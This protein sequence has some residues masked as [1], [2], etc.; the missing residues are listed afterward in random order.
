MPTT[1][2][3]HARSERTRNAVAEAMLDCFEDGLLR[4]GAHEVAER[5][6]VSTRA[7]FRH[8]DSMETLIEQVSEFQIERVM[9]QLPPVAFEGTREERVAALVARTSRAFELVAPVRRAA[10]LLEPFSRTIRE[11]HAWLRTEIRRSVRRAF[12]E[13]LD[14]LT[15]SRQRDRIAGLRALLSY[16]YWDELRRHE[17]LAVAAATRTLSA[18]IHALLRS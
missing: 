10:L 4:P 11:R 6:G 1:D 13:E 16:A 14:R 7:V 15:E 2:G 9:S 8:F 17:R 5:A 3:R 12:A 18:S